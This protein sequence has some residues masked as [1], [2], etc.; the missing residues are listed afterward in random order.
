MIEEELV[1]ILRM[2]SGVSELVGDRIYNLVISQ[3]SPLPAIAYQS[4]A[5]SRVRSHSGPSGLAKTVFQVSCFSDDG[6]EA[7]VLAEETRKALECYHGGD[8]FSIFVE[9]PQGVYDPATQLYYEILTARI[10][11]REVV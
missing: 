3:D 8:V 7:K 5:G 2:D 1:R 10:S 9:G 4:I 11:A 6:T